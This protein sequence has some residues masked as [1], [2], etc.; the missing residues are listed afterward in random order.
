M[1]KNATRYGFFACLLATSAHAGPIQFDDES[2][3]LGFE[4]GTESWGISWG[5]VNGDVWPDLYNHGHRDYT[6]LYRNTGS[7]DF[8][9]VTL[10]YDVQMGLW[11]L[12]LPQRDVHGAALA[13]F[14]NDGDDDVLI[15]DEDHFFV[16]HAE[17][18]GY[19]TQSS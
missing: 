13:D 5:N 6:R 11:W 10:E 12:S 15:G 9:D 2:D 14:D 3:K 17:S 16:N 7:G 4:R 1:N 19:F 8:D 18:G